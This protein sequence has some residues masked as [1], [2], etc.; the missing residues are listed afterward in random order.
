MIWLKVW[1][2]GN[3]YFFAFLLALRVG[4]GD[5]EAIAFSALLADIATA[6]IGMNIVA[7]LSL[8]FI[9]AILKIIK[10]K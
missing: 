4:G 1:L 6:I 2:L 9:W 7:A 8:G 3:I 5:L 10:G